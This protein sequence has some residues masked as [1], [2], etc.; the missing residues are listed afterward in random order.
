MK[1]QVVGILGGVGPLSTVYFMDR[2]LRL[3]SAQKDQDHVDMLV[4]NHA[5]IPDRTAFILGESADNPLP[6]LVEDARKLQAAGA[7]FLVLPCNTAHYFYDEISNAVTIPVLNIVESTI[8]Y[9]KH[10]VPE[11]RKLGVLATEGTMKTD[12][13]GLYGGR[14]GIEC[15]APDERGR[16]AVMRIIYEQVKAGRPADTDALFAEVEALKARG[17]GAV[18]LGCTELSVAYRDSGVH[19]PDIVDSLD[20]LAKSTVLACGKKLNTETE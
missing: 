12:T 18:V 9:A 19:R 1:A 4:T 8:A 13:Y 20:V 17:C 7:D 2:I 11:L 6:I 3:T 14:Q 10:A 15:V 5:T 16:A